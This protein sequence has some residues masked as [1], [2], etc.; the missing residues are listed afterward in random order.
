MFLRRVSSG[1]LLAVALAI[2][3]ACNSDTDDN[4]W[5]EDVLSCEEA[6]AH[7]DECCPG[8]DVTRVQCRYYYHIDRGCTTD[9]VTHV[10]P[11]IELSESHCIRNATCDKLQSQGNCDSTNYSA[12]A[13][14]GRARGVLCF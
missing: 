2:A 9:T 7:L 3:M 11:D 8:F 10:E 1:C 4:Q 14:G 5:R 6:V 13:D 12:K